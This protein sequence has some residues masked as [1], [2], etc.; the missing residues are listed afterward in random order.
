MRSLLILSS[1]LLLATLSNAA[2]SFTSP[3]QSTVWKTGET[4]TIKW[5]AAQGS[6]LSS[7]P[8]T[9]ELLQGDPK[10]L[11]QIVPSI[12]SVPE[13]AGQATYVVG[14][15]LTT[16]NQYALRAAGVYSGMFTI[17][18]NGP[19]VPGNATKPAN[20]TTPT[21]TTNT[22]TTPATNGTK[23]TP[24]TSPTTSA[25]SGANSVTSTGA[26]L[27]ACAAFVGLF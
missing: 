11:K 6:Q 25:K 18:N 1:T 3:V 16:S 20:G 13:S 26:L 22:A 7:T 12:A 9:I 17:Q 19:N 27:V 14:G 24:T 5:I 4:V 10:A 21:P 8:V 15:N 2:I 23:T